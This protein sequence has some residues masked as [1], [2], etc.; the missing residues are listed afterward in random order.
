M[1][2]APHNPNK[3]DLARDVLF[4]LITK[5]Y[6]RR[7]YERIDQNVG[8]PLEKA[9]A[10]FAAKAAEPG[11][12]DQRD[13]RRVFEDQHIRVRALRSYYETLRN[14][15]VWIYAVHE[16]LDTPDPGVKTACRG[17]V[18]DLI[19]REIENSKRFLELWQDAGSA[20]VEWMT[21]SGSGET[22]FI[23]GENFPDLLRRRMA[24][25][26]KHRSDEPFIDPDFMFRVTGD[27]Y[28]A[29]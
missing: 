1:C 27:P 20:G 23:Y 24:L 16:Y 8:P 18:D 14:T 17:L 29:S 11:G 7:A 2:T 22:A 21:V 3:V 5:D 19:D 15:A 4:E 10:L 6:A 28:S 12:E 25:M 13:S 9:L 26:E